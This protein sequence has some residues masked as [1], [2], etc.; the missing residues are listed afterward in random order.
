MPKELVEAAWGGTSAR[1]ND[2]RTLEIW[3]FGRVHRQRWRGQDKGHRQEIAAFVDWVLEGKPA[4]RVEEGLVATAATLAV[5]RSLDI[6][7][8]VELEVDLVSESP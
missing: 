5:L 1:I 7:Q 4:W 6:G 8:R 2:F 3:G